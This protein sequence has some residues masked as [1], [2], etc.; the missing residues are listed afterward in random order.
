MVDMDP[1]ASHYHAGLNLCLE[2]QHVLS[3]LSL[4]VS[5]QGSLW[6]EVSLASILLAHLI[7]L[8]DLRDLTVLFLFVSPLVDSKPL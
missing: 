3:L 6:L 2:E 7:H 4:Q 8:T 1:Q 5:P